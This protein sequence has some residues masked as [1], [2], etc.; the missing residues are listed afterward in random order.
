MGKRKLGTVI[1]LQSTTH[2]GIMPIVS[3]QDIPEHIMTW[4]ENCTEMDPKVYTYI[5]AETSKMV[6]GCFT[7][8]FNMEAKAGI[9][10]VT[11]DLKGM[12]V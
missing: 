3:D 7:M 8:G 9:V 2:K 4:E 1:L 11:D 5:R 12:G 10:D 6:K